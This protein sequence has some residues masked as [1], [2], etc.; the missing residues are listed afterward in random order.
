MEN[1]YPVFLKFSFRFPGM[2]TTFRQRQ[3]PEKT[4]LAAGNCPGENTVKNPVGTPRKRKFF[5]QHRISSAAEDQFGH[6]FSIQRTGA[7]IQMKQ[8]IEQ[9]ALI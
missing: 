7:D 8:T 9:C 3:Y 5:L 1:F 6:D 4:P 2:G